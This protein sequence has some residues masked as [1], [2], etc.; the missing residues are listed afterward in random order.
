M[1]KSK[2]VILA[3]SIL[4]GLILIFIYPVEKRLALRAYK[5]YS[6]AQG[7]EEADILDEK[8]Y[9]NYKDGGYKIIVK[10]KTDEN[11]TYVYSYYPYTHRKNEDLRFDRIFLQVS[12]P[13]KVLDPPYEGKVKYTPLEEK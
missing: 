3:I 8:I 4:L 12:D 5:G 9:K 2:K 6:L 1:K 7:V 13:I 10:Y 11:L